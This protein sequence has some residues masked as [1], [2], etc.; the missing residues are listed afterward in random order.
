[1][2]IRIIE[3]IIQKLK[4]FRRL[5]KE[6][7]IERLHWKTILITRNIPLIDQSLFNYIRGMASRKDISVIL[8]ENK[9]PTYM[10]KYERRTNTF[11][12]TSIETGTK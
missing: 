9:K 7:K 4:K 3:F 2:K 11:T 5:K 6:I 8:T 10:L 1:M 12:T